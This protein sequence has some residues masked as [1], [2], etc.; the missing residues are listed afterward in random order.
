[1]SALRIALTELRRITAGRLPRIAVLA[2]MIVPTLYGGLYVYANHDPYAATD[3]VPAALVVEDSGAVV[4][5]DRTNVGRRVADDLQEKANLD[6][7]RVSATTAEQGVRD[8]RYDFAL[9]IPRGFTTAL[10]SPQRQR[11]QQAQL[12]LTTNDA[13][14]YLASTIATNVSGQVRDAVARRLGA[15]AAGRF[16]LSL[17]QV[18]AGLV[19][20]A[21]GAGRLADGAR[22]AHDGA[23]QL[24]SGATRVDAGAEQLAA[25][26]S[27]LADGLS[28]LDSRTRDLPEQSRRL[29]EGAR[30]VADGDAAVEASGRH[31]A[32]AAQLAAQRYTEGRAQ[33]QQALAATDL[34]ADQ[35]QSLLDRYD[36]AG[37]PLDRA[38]GDVQQSSGRLD[39]LA[40]GVERV[41]DGT[42]RLADNAS[43]LS[44][45]ITSARRGADQLTAGSRQLTDGTRRLSDGAGELSGGTRRL[46][47]GASQLG[48]RLK[49]GA[50]RIPDPSASTRDRIA[51]TIGDPVRVASTSQASA[52][53]YGAGLAPFFMALAAWIGAYVLFLLVRPLSDRAL[54]SNQ[55]PLRVAVGGWLTPALVGVVQM[56]A[57]LATI[58][59]GLG[60]EPAHAALT[61]GF[62]VLVS[63]TFV[64]IVQTLNAWFGAVGQFLGL[65]L[66]VTQLVTAG[67]TFPWQTIPEPLH[68]LHHVL[69]MSYA[70]DGLRQLLYGGL[71]SLVTRD[72][73]VLAACLVG[74]LAL[75][76]VAARRRRVW[77][78]ARIRPELVL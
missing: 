9:T 10:T 30:Q 15:Q 19:D 50:A 46:A 72:A 75:S 59:I 22:S 73:L 76:T 70:V 28:S 33:L 34:P 54:A 1:M 45:G 44:S 4:D 41:A 18:R 6:W 14:S 36:A 57:L 77:T 53:T 56:G 27:R 35:Q 68:G 13:N 65:V 2:L 78:P 47:D 69:P 63:V 20:A 66:L 11:P 61:C 8:G 32:A 48:T 12:R 38:L 24:A 17:S 67:G 52:G 55:A 16:M 58:A 3:R 51:S 60:I 62:L 64:A 21:E 39:A 74:A 7:H 5:G 37:A 42:K 40:A 25:A 29:A 23:A 49:D 71:G 26:S 31:V 43:A